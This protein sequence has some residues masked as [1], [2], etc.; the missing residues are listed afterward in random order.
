[1][2]NRS[3]VAGGRDGPPFQ[4][5]YPAPRGV[6]ANEVLIRHGAPQCRFT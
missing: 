4:E 5:F 6:T 2:L 1:V 3:M